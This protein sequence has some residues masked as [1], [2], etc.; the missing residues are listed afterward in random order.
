MQKKGWLFRS[1]SE[2]VMPQNRFASIEV[3]ETNLLSRH[4][5]GSPASI[6][7]LATQ[8]LRILSSIIPIHFQIPNQRGAL[9]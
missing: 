5:F 1:N 4:F 9:S 8:E 7:T 6:L 3:R 2:G